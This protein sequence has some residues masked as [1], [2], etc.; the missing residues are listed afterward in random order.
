MHKLSST[1]DRAEHL[2]L[3][4]DD[5]PATRYSTCRILHAAGF[6][7]VEA[8]TGAEGLDRARAGGISAVVLDVHLPD[9]DGF[10]VC[11]M[12]RELPETVVLPVLHLSATYV[13]SSDK[14]AGLNSGADAYLEHPV[15]PAILVAT[16]QALIRARIAEEQLRETEQ[17]YKQLLLEREQVARA[18]AERHSRTKDDF[19]AV[20]S[21]ELRNPLNAILMNVHVL[22]RKAQA[23]DI[24]KGLDAIRRNAQTQ[25]RII[26]DIL[27]V[28]RINS[29]KL[30]LQ[31]EATDPAALVQSSIDAMRQQLDSRQLRLVLDAQATGPVLLDPARFQ[32]I[33]WNIFN[34]A[35][36]FSHPGG[37]VR[38][39][40]QR[41]AELLELTVEDT[42]RGIA[43]AF[44]DRVFEKFTQSEAPGKRANG[45]LGLGLSIVKHL[46]ELHGGGV[47]LTSPGLDAGTTVR[48]WLPVEVPAAEGEAA[49][50]SMLGALDDAALA[51]L[52]GRQVL[53][54]EDDR[55]AAEMLGH[56]L[57]DRGAQVAIAGDYDSGLAALQAHRP[58]LLLSDIGLPGKDGYALI[59]QWRALEARQDLP[60]L[61]A[62]ALTAFGRPDDRAMAL[63]A[64]FD[65]H[66]AKPF[67]P[68]VL[69][70]AIRR[71][72][73]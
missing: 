66:V 10:T 7:T 34:N 47:A 31:R 26:S 17:R 65:V 63:Q 37:S 15:E 9:I 2:V 54:V 13:E 35:I 56:I 16:L 42:G 60:R 43:P 25:A 73:G 64:G 20:L 18:N 51:G 12:L 49:P 48:V 52:S 30:A 45:G 57:E 1:I 5:T 67:E 6:K 41:N 61:P 32:Q 44:I 24:A 62:I 23:P 58:D 36:K 11:R 21:H 22:L 53:V 38:V 33:F 29:G 39:A 4:V 69:L 19:V 59:G 3:V 28:S 46:A 70:N 27:D 40:L 55:D 8:M 71:L 14:V 72:L 50:D 68:Q